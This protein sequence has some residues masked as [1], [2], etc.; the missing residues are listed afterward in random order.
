[1]ATLGGHRP[2]QFPVDAVGARQAGPAEALPSVRQ[3]IQESGAALAVDG[4]GHLVLYSG[5]ACSPCIT[6]EHGKQ[7]EC[8]HLTPLCQTSITVEHAFMRIEEHFAKVL[9][10]SKT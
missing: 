5:L 7:L 3:Q 10:K 9:G 2:G 4:E 8:W 6:V 1:M